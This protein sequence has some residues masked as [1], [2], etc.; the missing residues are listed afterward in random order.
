MKE[1]KPKCYLCGESGDDTYYMWV[2]QRGG[3][4]LAHDKCHVR[5]L[6]VI[7]KNSK[8]AITATEK[9]WEEALKTL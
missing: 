8:N 2:E 1:K 4:Y 3:G 7:R 9:A 5:V 6:G